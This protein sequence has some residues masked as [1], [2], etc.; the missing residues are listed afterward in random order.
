MVL[1]YRTPGLVNS[2]LASTVVPGHN[3]IRLRAR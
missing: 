3:K 2:N 1:A